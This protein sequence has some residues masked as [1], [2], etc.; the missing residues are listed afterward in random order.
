MVNNN[1]EN[2]VTTQQAAAHLGI[3]QS[4][5]FKACAAG[6]IPHAKIGRALRFRLSDLDA[7]AS[8]PC[9]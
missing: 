3:S 9:A 7:W 6:S 8:G 4:F 5:I 2:W 1:L